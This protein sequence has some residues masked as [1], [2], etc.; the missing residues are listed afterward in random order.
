[1]KAGGQKAMHIGGFLSKGK[2]SPKFL[3]VTP[4]IRTTHQASRNISR[5]VFKPG[6]SAFIKVQTIIT[7]FKAHSF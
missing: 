1:M 7:I 2:I 4:M 3:V 6:C 5:V